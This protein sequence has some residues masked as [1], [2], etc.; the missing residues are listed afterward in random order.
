MSRKITSLVLRGAVQVILALWVEATVLY[1][2]KCA[3]ATSGQTQNGC[4]PVYDVLEGLT[5]KQFCTH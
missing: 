4:G 5:I 1:R 2:L 3:L